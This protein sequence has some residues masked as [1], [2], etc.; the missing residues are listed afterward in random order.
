MHHNTLT[1]S[2]TTPPLGDPHYT[3][4]LALLN[5]RRRGPVPYIGP[6]TISRTFLI[7]PENSGSL[8]RRPFLDRS[9][10]HQISREAARHFR[11]V[12]SCAVYR[13]YAITEWRN[14]NTLRTIP[15]DAGET[16]NIIRNSM[17]VCKSGIFGWERFL[18]NTLQSDK[19]V[20]WLY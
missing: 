12:P 17:V 19:W 11:N 14:L 15:R 20:P 3:R 1:D 5:C 10:Q 9:R 13:N 8:Y 7:I 2:R 4:S 6:Q 18:A 16:Q